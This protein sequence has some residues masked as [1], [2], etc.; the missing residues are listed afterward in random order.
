MHENLRAS[1]CQL[2]LNRGFVRQ[3]DN[4]LKHR[5]KSKRMAS[6]EKIHLLEWP[7]QS[8]DLNLIE[9]LWYAF[10]PALACLHVMF[11]KNRK[12][13]RFFLRVLV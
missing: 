7:S 1:V 2:K 3:Q 13:H 6:Q 8:P 12:K 9:M 4:D 5:S 11:N 10:H